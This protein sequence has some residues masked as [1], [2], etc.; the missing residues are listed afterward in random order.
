MP[1]Q[2]NVARKEAPALV[3]ELFELMICT[4][5]PFLHPVSIAKYQR[6][7]V[8]FQIRQTQQG[9]YPSFFLLLSPRTYS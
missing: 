7:K 5:K 3:L 6:D 9:I 8:D 1:R 4:S 2:Y